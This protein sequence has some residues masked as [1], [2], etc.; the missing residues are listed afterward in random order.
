M[1]GRTEEDAVK[2]VQASIERLFY[3][4]AYSDK[5]GGSVQET[6]MYGASVAIHEPVGVIGIACP[7]VLLFFI[8]LK[9]I[10]EIVVPFFQTIYL[11][12]FLFY[13]ILSLD[14]PSFVLCFPLR[15]CYCP[16]KLCCRHSFPG[17]CSFLFPPS[18]FSLSPHPVIYLTHP[19]F[20][21]SLCF[22]FFSFLF[23]LFLFPFL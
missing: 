7:E 10:G 23:F 3:W 6:T 15:S 11:L 2:E 20:I 1:T 19:S 18:P 9:K 21:F 22:F 8:I 14:L 12:L 16:W 4:A 13:F 17:F 5:F